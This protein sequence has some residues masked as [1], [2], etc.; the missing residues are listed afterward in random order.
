MVLYPQPADV[1]Q[2]EADYINHMALFHEKTGIPVTARPYTVT[3]FLS[4]PEETATYYQM[5][6]MPF[7]SMEILQATMSSPAMQEIAA[8]ANRISSGG[9]ITVLIGNSE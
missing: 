5:F 3:K 7:E 1:Q 2:F 6:A 8:D 4:A 9:P